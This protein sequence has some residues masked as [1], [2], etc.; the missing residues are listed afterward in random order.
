MVKRC[1]K[2]FGQAWIYV[3]G[4]FNGM[5]EY[6]WC[7]NVQ[8]F[9][10]Q[11]DATSYATSYAT[12]FNK[13]CQDLCVVEVTV[14][15]WERNRGRSWMRLWRSRCG[16]DVLR[17]MTSR[18]S[19]KWSDE[20][21][22]FKYILIWFKLRVIWCEDLFF[23]PSGADLF[24]SIVFLCQIICVFM[25]KAS[26]TDKYT[27]I[28]CYIIIWYYIYTQLCIFI[29][30]I[31]IYILYIYIAI[32]LSSVFYAFYGNLHYL[33]VQARLTMHKW[34]KDGSTYFPL[35]NGTRLRDLGKTRERCCRCCLLRR[36]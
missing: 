24:K 12:S 15:C 17:N 5:S 28:H 8:T 13:I 35:T 27:D 31:Y 3:T 7:L 6:V 20:I 16:R 21:K 10:W 18:D 4:L 1:Q 34:K 26:Q 36:S 14:C 22:R 32:I 25:G 29:Y 33:T 30:I 11:Q 23:S 2:Q 19:K 9:S